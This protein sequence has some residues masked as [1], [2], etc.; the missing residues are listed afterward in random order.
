MDTR[1]TMPKTLNIKF[2]QHPVWT[3]C[4]C[5]DQVITSS[6][7]SR[8]RG[9]GKVFAVVCICCGLLMAS[10][11]LLLASL[12]EFTHYCPQCGAR[13]GAGKPK[14]SAKD[15]AIIAF[16]FLFQVAVATIFIFCVKKVLSFDP[17]EINSLFTMYERLEAATRQ[18]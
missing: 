11:L 16:I 9:G 18:E 1:V 14:L 6:V 4:P 3:E 12:R 5:C 8:I 7:E 13:L 2:G 10:L 15:L 17:Q